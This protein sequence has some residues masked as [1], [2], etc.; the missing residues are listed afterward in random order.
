MKPNLKFPL[1]AA[2]LAQGAWAQQQ[3]PAMPMRD[4]ATHEQLTAKLRVAQQADPM[5][6]LE[7]SK[8]Q[9]PVKAN[10]IPN[11]LSQSDIVCFGGCAT[12]VPK[13]AVLH[14]PPNLAER[15]KIQ[16]GVQIQSWAD[17]YAAN[18][19]WITTVEVTRVQAEGRQALAEETNKSLGESTQLV[20]ATYQ[21]GPISVLPLKEEPPAEATDP[22]SGT[23]GKPADKPVAGKGKAAA[24]PA[25][26][27]PT[28]P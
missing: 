19:G 4:A 28:K 14:L 16:P 15:M 2:V 5:R 13:R 12:L 7:P 25:H 27:K 11:L 22:A 6:V 20:V 8:G 9:D 23:T 10:P 1:L 21:G 18:R 26:S 17:F 24:Q 3:A